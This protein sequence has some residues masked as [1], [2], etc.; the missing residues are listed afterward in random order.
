MLPHAER[1][2]MDTVW[3]DLVGP[4]G[5]HYVMGLGTEMSPCTAG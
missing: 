5:H 4:V 1:T 2:S 3:W